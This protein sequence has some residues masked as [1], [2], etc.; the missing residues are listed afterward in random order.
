MPG[1]AGSTRVD[2]GVTK[3]KY[4][5]EMHVAA[6]SHVSLPKTGRMPFSVSAVGRK[7]TKVARQRGGTAFGSS[8]VPEPD[9]TQR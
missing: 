8:T 4:P 6:S 9:V 1:C 3:P 5:A 7:P 2:S